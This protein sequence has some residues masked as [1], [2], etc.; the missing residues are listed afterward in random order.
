MTNFTLAPTVGQGNVY[1]GAVNCETDEKR[2]DFLKILEIIQ[3]SF[4]YTMQIRPQSDYIVIENKINL[5]FWNYI[6]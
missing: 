4:N 1:F 3:S 5:W 2:N 6:S